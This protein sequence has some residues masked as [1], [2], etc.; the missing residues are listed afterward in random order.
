MRKEI[1]HII[2]SVLNT[3]TALFS[4]VKG[5]LAVSGNDQ[6][7]GRSPAI[8]I[9]KCLR[10]VRTLLAHPVDNSYLLQQCPFIETTSGPPQSPHSQ[11][12]LE[13]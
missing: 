10:C 13:E 4:P 2:S 1:W 3:L 5:Q 6:L 11:N 7:T 12:L 9:V 8:I